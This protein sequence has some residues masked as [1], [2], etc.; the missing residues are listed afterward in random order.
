MV[1][2]LVAEN[3]GM[4][5][6]LLDHRGREIAHPH[7]LYAAFLLQLSHGAQ[8]LLE[9][10]AGVGPVHE[11]KVDVLGLEL[12][13]APAGRADDA[14]VG[15]AAGPYFG[16]EEDVFAVRTRVSYAAPDLVLVGIY[17]SSVDMP[18]SQIEGALHG[19]DAFLPGEPPGTQAQ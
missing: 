9:G 19:L 13:E 8:G 10:H 16:D 7:M 17:L 15:E 3:L 12:L 5:R 11:Q 14:I 2:D 6:S 1:L 4:P 18:V